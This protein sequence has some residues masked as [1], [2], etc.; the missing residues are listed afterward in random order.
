MS[1]PTENYRGVMDAGYA[2]GRIEKRHLNY[3][4]RVRARVAADAFRQFHP[5]QAFVN[6]CEFGAADGRTLLEIRELVGARGD[7][8]GVEYAEELLASAPRM[9]ED[10]RM[11]QGDVMSLPDE[12]VARHWDL[13]SCLA[14]LEHLPDPQ[15][16][17]DEAFR[18]LKPGGVFVATCPNPFWDEVAGMVGLV[19]DEYHE[20]EVTPEVLVSLCENSG[21]VNVAF[22]PFMWVFTGVLPYLGLELT[23]E[24]SLEIDHLIHQMGLLDFLFVN[25][26]VVAQKP[27]S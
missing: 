22:R 27:Y 5:D 26:A 7:Y 8:L 12:V 9:P 1:E 21:F 2:E 19:E 10:S 14:V 25:Q 23:P 20:L 16:C 4:Y 15:A 17:V 18:V 24:F 6:V 11:I 13:V 3:R